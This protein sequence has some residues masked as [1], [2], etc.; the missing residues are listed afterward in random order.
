MI[1]N[2]EDVCMGFGDAGGLLPASIATGDAT[3]LALRVVLRAAQRVYREYQRQLFDPEGYLLD[4]IGTVRVWQAVQRRGVLSSSRDVLLRAAAVTSPCG[5]CSRRATLRCLTCWRG[6]VKSL[7]RRPR[8]TS[9]P[10][11]TEELQR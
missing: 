3:P 6:T 7:S 1:W 11:T 2:D 5:L 9:E 4:T 10:W 8:L